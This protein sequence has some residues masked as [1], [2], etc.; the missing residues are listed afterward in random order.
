M[1][2]VPMVLVKNEELW[3]GK[4]LASLSKVFPH[5]I[6]A[7][8]GSTDSTREQV[9]KVPN[10]K[11]MTYENLTPQQ[12]GKCREWMQEEAKKS[13]G[14]THVMLVDGDEL[15]PLK[16]L[17]YILDNP[18]PEN[19]M[20]GFTYGI[21]CTELQNGECWFLG[22]QGGIVG[23]N[24]QAIFSVDSKWSGDYPFESPDSYV[25]GDPSNHYFPAL[26]PGHHF[27]HLHQMQRSTKDSDV[28]LRVQ[29]RYQFS[30][31]EHPDIVPMIKWLN[32]REEYADE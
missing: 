23:V 28:Y 27:Y 3:I 21:E 24:R 30:M 11:L 12:V 1:N 32:R 15:Y 7:D 8:T 14:A 20:S 31:A 18:M 5:V 10:V 4:V 29:K 6:V 2:I 22:R 13:F 16:Y 9:A 19:A 25:A 26:E 17:R